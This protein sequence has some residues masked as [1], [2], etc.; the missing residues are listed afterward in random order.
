M[1]NYPRYQK[2]SDMFSQVVNSEKYSKYQAIFPSK[3]AFNAASIKRQLYKMDCRISA[4]TLLMTSYFVNKILRRSI[5]GIWVNQSGI[6]TVKDL[7]AR[8]ER[9]ILLPT[10]KSFVDPLVIYY[11]LAD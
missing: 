3:L 9:V 7:L 2:L 11:S 10:F 8:G 1:E 6:Q 4:R 5:E